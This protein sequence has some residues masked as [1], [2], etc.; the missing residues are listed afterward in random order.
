WEIEKDD[1]EGMTWV[2]ATAEWLR[3]SS[4]ADGP[5]SSTAS[6]ERRSRERPQLGP[7]NKRFTLDEPELRWLVI[8]RVLERI[9]RDRPILLWLDDFHHAPPNTYEGLIKIRRESPTLR[10]L[11]VATAR[12]EALIGDPQIERRLEILRRTFGGPRLRLHPLD[13]ADTQALL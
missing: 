10:T 3:P 11:I 2:A 9:G 6:T 7:T 13:E 5:V 12:H 1:E 4:Y 8:K